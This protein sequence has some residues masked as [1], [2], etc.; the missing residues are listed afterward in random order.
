MAAMGLEQV[1]SPEDLAHFDEHGC[2]FA[3]RQRRLT[4]PPPHTHPGEPDRCQPPPNLSDDVRR[5]RFVVGRGIISPEQA[6]RTAAD[7]WEFA[8]REEH[9]ELDFFLDAGD[10]GTWY[11]EAG[12]C[13]F[14]KAVEVYHS[15]AMWDNKCVLW[16]V[17]LSPDPARPPTGSRACAPLAPSSLAS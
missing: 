17:P 16:P 4:S 9:R 6:A 1:L 10:E 14:K 15:Q 7:I 13:G 12:N 3:H 5:G 8:G 11:D 2:A